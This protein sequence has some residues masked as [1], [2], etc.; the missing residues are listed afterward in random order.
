MTVP[1]SSEF[2][3]T[4]QCDTIPTTEA[5]PYLFEALEKAKQKLL[6]AYCKKSYP[7]DFSYFPF[8]FEG[9]MWDLNV[10][11]PDHCLSFYFSKMVPVK[12]INQSNCPLKLKKVLVLGNLLPVESIMRTRETYDITIYEDGMAVCQ[13]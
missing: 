8:G 5:Q 7:A 13:L 4:G 12:I 11:V 9:R 6:I 10:L 1:A 3:M 2:V